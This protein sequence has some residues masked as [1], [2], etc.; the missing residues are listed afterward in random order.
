MPTTLQEPATPGVL[1]YQQFK[2]SM[3]KSKSVL[4]FNVHNARCL[5]LLLRGTNGQQPMRCKIVCN[6]GLEN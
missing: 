5:E 3:A 2:V 6:L 4:T 1:R